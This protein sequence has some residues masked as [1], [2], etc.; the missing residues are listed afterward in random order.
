MQKLLQVCS[1]AATR[2]QLCLL[3]LIQ[4]SRFCSAGFTQALLDLL[5]WQIWRGSGSS[6][7]ANSSAPLM[8]QDRQLSS[9]ASFTVQMPLMKWRWRFWS[10]FAKAKAASALRLLLCRHRFCFTGA[11][12]ASMATSYRS[13]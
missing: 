3:N 1:S 10:T 2:E 8:S 12:Y 11:E 4:S 5:D 7:A 13:S 9:G 6:S